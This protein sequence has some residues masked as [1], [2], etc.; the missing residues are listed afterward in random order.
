MP[1]PCRGL[2]DRVG[3]LTFADNPRLG[4]HA[5]ALARGPLRFDFDHSFDTGCIVA[6][7]APRPI[8]GALDQASFHWIAVDV[9]QL[10]DSLVVTP[11]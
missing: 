8:L 1:H 4:S 3:I 7:A 2:C 5:L 11:R 9:A 10:L 6:E